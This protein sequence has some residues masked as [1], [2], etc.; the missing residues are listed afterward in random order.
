MKEKEE[1]EEGAKRK[2]EKQLGK[3]GWSSS[4][5]RRRENQQE[6]A[7]LISRSESRNEKQEGE[8]GAKRKSEKQEGKAGWSSRRE[9]KV[10][11]AVER[12]RME[13]QEEE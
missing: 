8:E 12:S 7:G 3:A 11:E 10:G 1:G 9:E 5:R 6:E 2:S 13:K 4:G